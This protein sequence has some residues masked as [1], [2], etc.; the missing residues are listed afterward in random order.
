MAH[1]DYMFYEGRNIDTP[2]IRVNSCPSELS[3]EDWRRMSYSMWMQHLAETHFNVH[4]LPEI[5]YSFRG[6]QIG[7]STVMESFFSGEGQHLQYIE[8]GKVPPTVQEH[9][10]RLLAQ[11]PDLASD[12]D[13][14]TFSMR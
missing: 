8:N 1:V 4:S 10:R 6:N 9:C 14:W 13:K 2:V 12:F 11:A 7:Y 5:T 3:E